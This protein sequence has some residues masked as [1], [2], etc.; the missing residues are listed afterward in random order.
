LAFRIPH[1]F[2]IE[3]L[4]RRPG[5]FKRPQ[6]RYYCIR[7]HW[8]FLVEGMKVCAL[9]ESSEPL[10]EPENGQRVASF[11]LGPCITMPPERSWRTR[12]IKASGARRKATTVPSLTGR[13]GQSRSFKSIAFPNPKNS[14]PSQSHSVVTSSAEESG[15][16]T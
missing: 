6:Y 9:N 4:G 12:E 7:C 5:W 16:G 2:V 10:S 8:I 1:N 15:K 3:P 13:L 14:R 11:A